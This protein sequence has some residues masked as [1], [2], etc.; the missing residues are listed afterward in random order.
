MFFNLDLVLSQLLHFSDHEIS[1]QLNLI[2]LCCS[3]EGWGICLISGLGTAIIKPFL[4]LHKPV[5]PYCWVGLIPI[6]L[7]LIAL[8]FLFF[9]L[10]RDDCILIA[11]LLWFWLRWILTMSTFTTLL[12]HWGWLL[13]LCLLGSKNTD[14]VRVFLLLESLSETLMGWDMGVGF[15][16]EG[17]H[18]CPSSGVELGQHECALSH[19]LNPIRMLLAYGVILFYFW[20][21]QRSTCWHM[22]N[23]STKTAGTLG[24]VSIASISITL[25]YI[26]NGQCSLIRDQLW[27]RIVLQVWWFR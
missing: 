9:R 27:L 22:V 18:G 11:D 6:H 16:H 20:E 15:E 17:A 2:C 8:L 13:L 1:L 5:L 23:S 7:L 21:N 3:L 10:I 14:V 24:W 25:F 19:L 26:R 12:W 4:N